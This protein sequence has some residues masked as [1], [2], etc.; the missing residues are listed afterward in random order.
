M[1][2]LFVFV[3]FL[4]LVAGAATFL[5]PAYPLS[6]TATT[7][8]LTVSYILFFVV[9]SFHLELTRKL[10][11][12]LAAFY[13][14]TFTKTYVT[15]TDRK[16]LERRYQKPGSKLDRS[17]ELDQFLGRGMDWIGLPDVVYL[18]WPFYSVVPA[19][20]AQL[21]VNIKV[22]D[23][24]WTT[25]QELFRVIRTKRVTTKD[26]PGKVVH[27]SNEE[28][29]EGEWTAV[30][31]TQKKP[32]IPRTKTTKL[33][34]SD[35]T[36]NVETTTEEVVDTQMIPRI[37]LR[38]D[39][40][41]FIRLGINL[42]PLVLALPEA[43]LDKPTGETEADDLG[44]FLT[45]KIEPLIHEAVWEGVAG[46]T[47]KDRS[48]KVPGLTWEGLADTA[49]SRRELEWRIREILGSQPES[50]LVQSGLL[51]EWDGDTDTSDNGQSAAAFDIVIEHVAPKDEALQKAIDAVAVARKQAEAAAFDA[52][53]IR[54]RERGLTDALKERTEELSVSGESALAHDFG[55]NTKADL[56]VVA[57]D[58]AS[59]LATLFKRRK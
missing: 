47:K 49:K 52:D 4:V 28:R 41:V 53:A 24:V 21:R 27:G 18:Q 51:R 22:A 57:P 9:P 43:P 19:T 14:G 34:T 29:S 38:V 12:R 2:F 5:L 17:N 30:T 40:E 31:A 36:E 37:Q 3:V 25:E 45:G 32:P 26:K 7:I 44:K 33:D 50:I 11:I 42:G 35:P 23:G 15:D 56:T 8:V 13:L 58:L 55:K 48:T 54:R 10:G 6:F 46:Y 20:T 1:A 59:A 39:G 16:D